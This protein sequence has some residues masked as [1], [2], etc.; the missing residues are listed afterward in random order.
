MNNNK[1]PEFQKAWDEAEKQSDNL[2]IPFTKEQ[3]E[4]LK[5]YYNMHMNHLPREICI[6]AAVIAEDGYIARGHRHHNC[7]AVLR[8]MG[9]VPQPNHESQ[10]FITSK[11]RY[12]N[13]V[14]GC[15]LQ[16]EAGI[17]SNDKLHP[18]MGG[19]LYSEDLY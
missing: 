14:E 18:Y 9:K 7:I 12:V 15:R 5:V 11:N 1:D 16:K 6:C 2:D 13:R 4:I 19:E 8:A 3:R 10:G 17:E